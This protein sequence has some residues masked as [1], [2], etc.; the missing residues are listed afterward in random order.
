M[1]LKLPI[2]YYNLS[3]PVPVYQRRWYWLEYPE[4]ANDVDRY[5]IVRL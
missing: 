1:L 5:E 4:D 3:W 2:R